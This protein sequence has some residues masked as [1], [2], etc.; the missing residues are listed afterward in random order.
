MDS[1]KKT[2]Y[3]AWLGQI[4]SIMGFFLAMPLMPLYIAE[5]EPQMSQGELSQWA[6]IVNGVTGLSMAIFAPIWGVLADRYGRKM[7]VLRSMF[8]GVLV[9]TLMGFASSIT[10][11]MILRI[12]QG[13]LTGTVTASVA[14][15]SSVS[16]R[17]R[18]G[19][20]LGMM[21]GA[22]VMGTTLGPF[23]GGELAEQFGFKVTFFASAAIVLVGGLLVRLFAHEEFK[24][25]EPSRQ[26]RFHSLSEMFG[27][28]G[29]TA[30]LLAL[31]M[32]RFGDSIFQ[33]ILP[34][35]L[36]DLMKTDEGVRALTG[37]LIG[38][39]G[40]AAFIASATLGH[41]SDRWGHKRLL[42]WSV[43]FASVSTLT[44]AFSG[45]VANLFVLRVIFGFAAAGIMP[46]ANAII[47]NI[48]Q[49]K[50][51]GKAYGIQ[52]SLT[53]LGWGLGSICGGHVA[54]AF[55]LRAPFVVTAAIF[56]LAAGFVAWR[57]R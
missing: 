56:A 47:R 24:R 26:G 6:G 30:A 43:L 8:G 12:L 21:Q 23:L 36:R 49:D 10:Q 51:L 17:E 35:F 39:S 25:P 20:T 54:A 46:S 27:V 37:R 33:P 1:W 5:L 2:F 16:P 52:A 28:A 31:F 29:F 41:I 3:S 34:Y 45:S 14:L 38:V 15:V 4:F 13:C 22:V 11:I 57:V 42:I 18:A 7:M 40:I 9:L 50:H 55:G 48:M 32:V 44:I 19:Y 53:G